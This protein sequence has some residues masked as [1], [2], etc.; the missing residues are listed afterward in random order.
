MLGVWKGEGWLRS[1]Q[2]EELFSWPWEQKAPW[3]AVET[4]PSCICRMNVPFG[5]DGNR[6]LAFSWH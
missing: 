6:T 4:L 2:P 5:D 3:I 1:E